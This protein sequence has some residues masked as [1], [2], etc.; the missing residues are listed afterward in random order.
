M[1]HVLLFES[2]LFRLIGPRHPLVCVND[3][4]GTNGENYDSPSHRS[5]DDTCKSCPEMNDWTLLERKRRM[6]SYHLCSPA[7]ATSP[8]AVWLV[9]ESRA[10]FVIKAKYSSAGFPKLSC[11]R[12]GAG[13][14]VGVMLA[15]DNGLGTEF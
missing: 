13:E 7:T 12:A 10:V 4:V 1:T 3:A 9:G 2:F 14:S 11:K 5:D 6:E 15:L 8:T